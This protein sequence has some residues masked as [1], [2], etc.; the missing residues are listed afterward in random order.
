MAQYISLLTQYVRD[1]IIA[2]NTVGNVLYEIIS[3]AD[4]PMPLHRDKK[5]R[6]LTI[7]SK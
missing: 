2:Q 6:T 7:R 5:R 1:D 4:F 3:I